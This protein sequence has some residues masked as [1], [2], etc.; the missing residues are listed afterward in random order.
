M[1]LPAPFPLPKHYPHDIQS[2]LQTKKMSVK[3]KQRFVSEIASAMLRFTNYPTRDDYFCVARTVLNKY[4]FLKTSDK[5]PYVSDNG[6]R[7][8][9]CTCTCTMYIIVAKCRHVYVHVHACMY[10]YMHVYTCTCT[11]RSRHTC[12][13]NSEAVPPRV[14]CVCVVPKPFL[15]CMVWA[16]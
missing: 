7:C 1:P 15:M 8:Y 2:A 4:P 14:E 6:F 9:T 11:C 3:D 16:S 12:T 13:C 10:M 5:K